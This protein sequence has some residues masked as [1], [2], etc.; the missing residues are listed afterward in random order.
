MSRLVKRGILSLCSELKSESVALVDV[1]APPDFILNSA[2]GHSDGQ[3]KTALGAKVMC[4]FGEPCR[5]AKWGRDGVQESPASHVPESR[6]DVQTLLV[7]GDEWFTQIQALNRTL[8]RQ[9]NETG[10]QGI[11]FH[12]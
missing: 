4:L 3:L 2:L 7:E 1:L 8:S 12:T 5:T 10:S 6:R 11:L 9:E